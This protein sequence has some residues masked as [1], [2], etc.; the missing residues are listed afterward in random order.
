MPK[1]ITPLTDS[2][3]NKAKLELKAYKLFDGGGL[4]LLVKPNGAKN[5]RHKYKKPDGKETTIS[6]GDYPTITLKEARHLREL[7]KQQ[8]TKSIDPVDE[9]RKQIERLKYD[10]SFKP[11]AI[12]WLEQTATNKKWVL[13]YKED[14]TSIINKYLMPTLAKKSIRDISTKDLTKVI[15]KLVSSGKLH[16][17]RRTRQFIT[18]IFNYATLKGLIDNNPAFALSSLVIE[19]KPT[20]R[21]VIK[22]DQLPKLINDIQ[23]NKICDPV[24]RLA[25]LINLHLFM[26]A[27]ELV[28]ARWDEINLETKLWTLPETRQLINGNQETA[29]GA[30]MKTPHLIPLSKQVIALLKELKPFTFPTGLVFTKNMLTPISNITPNNA[31]RSM[32]YGKDEL[33]MHGFRTL[34]CSA[35]IESGLFSKDAIERQMSHIERNNVRAAYI[36][37]AEHLTE[38][39]NIMNWWSDYITYVANNG[40]IAPY[41]FKND[42]IDKLG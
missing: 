1:L 32:G 14:V 37:N 27:S 16:T 15:E 42:S 36:H 40:Y 11:I 5:W 39:C 34:A 41:D 28:Y 13:S 8:L 24:V 4:Y 38:R 30:K 9:K 26:R 7:T 33:T 10:N 31:L 6:Y 22:L 20:N 12:D 18:G 25:L 23:D 19:G 29:R 21:A 35:L 2:K 17:A 3:V